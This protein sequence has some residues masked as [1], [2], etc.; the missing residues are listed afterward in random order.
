MGSGRPTQSQ[1]RKQYGKMGYIGTSGK[2]EQLVFS[3][4]CILRIFIFFAHVH[5]FKGNLFYKNHVYPW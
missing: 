4:I 3:E 5:L 2:L 1:E